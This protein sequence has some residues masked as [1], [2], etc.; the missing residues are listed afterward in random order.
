MPPVCSLSGIT[1][2]DTQDMY[3]AEKAKYDHAQKTKATCKAEMAELEASG[4]TAGARYKKLQVRLANAEH[5]EWVQ[6]GVV[7]RMQYSGLWRPP[8]R[9]YAQ[10]EAEVKQLQERVTIAASHDARLATAAQ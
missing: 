8:T 4:A 7:M 6:Y 3:W 10:C 5:E 1:I 2:W 9:A